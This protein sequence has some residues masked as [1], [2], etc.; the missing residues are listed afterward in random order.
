MKKLVLVLCVGLALFVPSWA[1]AGHCNRQ[2]IVHYNRQ[3]VVHYND[4][5]DNVV[6]LIVVQP[7]VEY[8]ADPEV[9][10]EKKERVVE[11]KEIERVRIVRKN[12]VVN[13]IQ[14]LLVPVILKE[15]VHY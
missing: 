4:C 11:V 3:N 9:D 12:K 13:L 14:Q 5:Y 8:I 7:Q 10:T 2:N 1:F 15:K 6:E